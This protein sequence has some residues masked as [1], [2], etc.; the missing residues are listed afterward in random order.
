MIGDTTFPSLQYQVQAA[1]Y[2]TGGAPH[3][4]DTLSY[5]SDGTGGVVP[6]PGQTVT[7]DELQAFVGAHVASYKQIREMEI[8]S[9]IPK[10]ASGKILRRELRAT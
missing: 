1:Y 7:L 9:E 5:R 3:G 10:S 2:L 6:V 4:R 8:R